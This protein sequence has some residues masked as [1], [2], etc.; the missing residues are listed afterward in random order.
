MATLGNANNAS[1]QN[2][3]RRSY[4]TT[5]AF[6]QYFYTYT[7]YLENLETKGR[8]TQVAGTDCTTCPAGRILRENGR[9][10]YPKANPGVKYYMVGVYDS[11]TFLSGYIFPNANIFTIY[12]S[13]RPTYLREEDDGGESTDGDSEGSIDE[14]G[15]LN[16]GPPV[17]TSG[18]VLS[19]DGFLGILSS[20]N[21]GD[22]YA[23]SY[24]EYNQ[25][26]VEAGVHYD[27]ECPGT[28]PSTLTYATMYPN[29]TIESVTYV[30][31]GYTQSSIVSITADGNIYNTGNVS[32]MGD[33]YI[34]GDEL[35]Q[36]NLSTLGSAY[37]AGT[38][39][40]IGITSLSGGVRVGN[41]QTISKI[42]AGAINCVV[43]SQSYTG[44]AIYAVTNSVTITATVNDAIIV[45]ASNGI[46]DFFLVGS[47]ITGTNT[48]TFYLYCT[49]G[50]TNTLSSTTGLRYTLIQNV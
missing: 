9:K 41:G 22:A 10:L 13:D 31:D 17:L 39:S 40:T 14:Y 46:P 6:D 23:G 27:L 21:T 30:T 25:P 12:N 29:G 5:A 26:I 8:L 38:L 3:S 16:Y 37:I 20:I 32:T 15:G 48:V 45:N 1:Q 50:G 24:M 19:S 34:Q 11:V 43:P 42:T 49:R 7:T 47:S 33:T 28:L 18:N 36:G 2:T 35:V 4:I 44:G